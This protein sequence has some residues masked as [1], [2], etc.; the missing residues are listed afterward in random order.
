MG[1][2]H[3]LKV[4]LCTQKM[5]QDSHL[6]IQ[7]GLAST[8]WDRKKMFRTG[9]NVASWFSN[10]SALFW[11]VPCFRVKI[12]YNYALWCISYTTITLCTPYFCTVVQ[13]CSCPQ[14]PCFG[15][16]IVYNYALWCIS[17][18]A[19]TL[20]TPYFCTVVQERA[21]PR[22]PCF[23]VK[24]VHNYGLCCISYTASTLYTPYFCTV[25]QERACPPC[26]GVKI[27]HNYGLCCISYTASTLYTPYFCTVVQE[28]ACPRVPCFGVKIVHNYRLCCISYTASTL[29]TP[30]FCTVVQERACP[31]VQFILPPTHQ[32]INCQQLETNP[33]SSI[34][35]PICSGQRVHKGTNESVFFAEPVFV[36]L[37]RSPGIDSQLVGPERQPY[38]SYRPA[39]LHRLAESVPRN[40]FL[41]SFIVYK[42]GFW[43]QVWSGHGH[44]VRTKMIVC[45]EGT[46]HSG[47]LNKCSI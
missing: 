25:V 8:R 33:Y 26:F 19:S 1:S 17:Y 38:L 14:V 11:K 36:N 42:Y 15:V 10:C 24:I 4:P 18:T 3:L 6:Y 27:V 37:L 16:K 39:R 7:W 31:R 2:E 21:C 34:T 46:L 5:E 22:V 40:R 20:Y 12:V 30:S 28:R 35:E 45:R 29:Y 13:E 44:R 23:G 47:C 32:K 43:S 9:A 41:D